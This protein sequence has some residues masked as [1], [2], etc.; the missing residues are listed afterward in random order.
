MPP[1][2][3]KAHEIGKCWQRG[4]MVLRGCWLR[5][6]CQHPFSHPAA[7]SG[8]R[9]WWGHGESR[10]C[11]GIHH[12]WVLALL[13][14]LLPVPWDPSSATANEAAFS[15]CV[16]GTL[17]AAWRDRDTS[18][19]TPQGYQMKVPICIIR[20][21]QW[22]GA[23]WWLMQMSH[24]ELSYCWHSLCYHIFT[25]RLHLFERNNETTAVGIFKFVICWCSGTWSEEAAS[26]DLL[27][28]PGLGRVVEVMQQQ[29]FRNSPNS[30]RTVSDG[31]LSASWKHWVE[32]T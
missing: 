24:L 19:H 31:L 13:H 23:A 17:K 22:W 5:H 30:S 9:A 12:C 10:G 32:S 4:G 8:G 20:C 28:S 15:K 18:S 7:M 6:S 29:C 11:S 26:C 2:R 3:L 1:L 16:I 21:Q 14:A 25:E 27:L